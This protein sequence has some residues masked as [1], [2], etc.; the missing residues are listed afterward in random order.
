MVVSGEWDM[1][2]DVQSGNMLY[3]SWISSRKGEL[4][5]TN[6]HVSVIGS[7]VQWFVL[8]TAVNWKNG[9][10]RANKRHNPRRTLAIQTPLLITMF[11]FLPW[12]FKINKCDFEH[13]IYW[14]AWNSLRVDSW[15]SDWGA[16]YSNARTHTYTHLNNRIRIVVK[17]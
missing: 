8:R 7:V 4:S 16:F 3:M 14:I 17:R 6:F 9:V 15:S 10:A 5:M 12:V 13:A 11:I 2:C 1:T